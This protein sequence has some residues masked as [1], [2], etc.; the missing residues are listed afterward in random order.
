M[1]RIRCLLPLV[2]CLLVPLSA[3]AQWERDV[4]LTDNSSDSVTCFNNARCVAT[5]GDTIHV[6][7]HDGRD[8][9]TEIYYKSSTDQGTTWGPDVCLTPTAVVGYHPSEAVSGSIVHVAWTDMSAGPR[10]RTGR[11]TINAALRAA[12]AW[13]VMRIQPVQH[14]CSCLRGRIPAR[15]RSSSGMPSHRRGQSCWRST[16]RPAHA[17]AVSQDAARSP[18]RL[19]G[20]L[21]KT[22]KVLPGRNV[23]HEAAQQMAAGS[24]MSSRAAKRSAAAIG[25]A[26]YRSMPALKH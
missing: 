22:K 21:D 12:R 6:V 24:V 18:T 14:R 10:I 25:L 13:W 17:I 19:C 26:R 15:V 11:C 20:R 4:R 5:A 16:L 7:W 1:R 23:R 3:L 2:I 8:G 9:N